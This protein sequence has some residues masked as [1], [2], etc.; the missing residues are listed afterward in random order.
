MEQAL[1]E[2]GERRGWVVILEGS[3]C[4]EKQRR[5]PL[6]AAPRAVLF[7]VGTVETGAAGRGG[8]AA[9]GDGRG[10][11]RPAVLC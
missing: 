10:A 4:L 2:R 5:R 9:R 8:A 1:C 11:L 6:G 7:W 3:K